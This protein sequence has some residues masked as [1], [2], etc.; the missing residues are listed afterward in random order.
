MWGIALR[1][2][3]PA[4][5]WFGRALGWVFGADL[6]AML[7]RW[8]ASIGCGIAGVAAVKGILGTVVSVSAIVGFWNLLP[9][10][11]FYMASVIGLGTGIQMMITV[12]VGKW[13]LKKIEE[14]CK[15]FLATQIGPPKP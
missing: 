5:G 10:P 15:S 12:Y 14:T 2:L 6:I 8:I 4:L 9:P 7:V 3:T 11:V 13:M 1:I